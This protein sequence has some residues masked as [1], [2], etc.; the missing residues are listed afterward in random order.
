M[1]RNGCGARL[2]RGLKTVVAVDHRQLAVG[3]A[4]DLDRRR[5]LA[6]GELRARFGE[7]ARVEGLRLEALQLVERDVSRLHPEQLVELV[8]HVADLLPA[9]IERGLR[10]LGNVGHRRERGDDAGVERESTAGALLRH[11]IEPH[12]SGLGDL[13]LLELLRRARR[14]R[15]AEFGLFLERSGK[16]RQRLLDLRRER[17]HSG[18]ERLAQRPATERERGVEADRRQQLLAG[19]LRV[20]EHRLVQ[21]RAGAVEPSLETG[22]DEVAGD[23]RRDA[24]AEL[25]RDALGDGTAGLAHQAER[26][27]FVRT[28]ER[29]DTEA[30]GRSSGVRL[31]VGLLEPLQ[32]PRGDGPGLGECEI[33]ESERERAR[34]GCG[35]RGERADPRTR[36][37]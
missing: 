11:R 16:I 1:R 3:V 26:G 28:G 13:L 9:R 4:D 19:Q 17:A 29:A 12:R 27:D 31:R 25:L 24:A 36:P 30:H 14:L 37:G 15:G 22:S 6:R 20:P 33:R 34:R 10:A 5:R 2:A 8:A 21:R 32:G 35:A 7:T 23:L 18:S